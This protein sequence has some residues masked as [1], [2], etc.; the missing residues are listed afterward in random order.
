MSPDLLTTALAHAALGW[1]V[2]PLVPG[3][4][5]PVVNRWEAR[6][7]TD[8]DRIRAAWSAGQ[9]GIGIACGPS[10]LLVLDLDMPKPGTPVPEHRR[11]AGITCGQDMLAAVC[12]DAG[13]PWPA[14]YTVATPSG[15][16][17]LYYRQ[18]DGEPLRNSH[19][20]TAN[21][22]GK[23]IDTR[24]AGGY[25]AAPGTRLPNGAYSVLDHAP[26]SDL[27]GWLTDRLRGL[28]D[29]TTP[30]TTGPVRVDTSHLSRYLAAAIDR[31]VEKVLS[32]PPGGHNMTVY[33]ASASLGQLVAGGA[34]SADDVIAALLPAAMAVGQSERE[35]RATIASGMRRG[36]QRPRVA[37]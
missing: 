20:G 36:A 13:Q 1:H 15:G 35:A 18:P 9:Y 27:P 22:L 26:V 24:G 6:A 31:S 14:T 37:A 32:S 5:L 23:L 21:G 19:G 30:T 8:P 28:R 29:Q 11:L 34:L 12:E 7:T 4:K 33:G 10:G 16:R 25:I 17:H 2:F 3:A